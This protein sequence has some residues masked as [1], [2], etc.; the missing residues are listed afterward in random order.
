MSSRGESFSVK[1]LRQILTSLLPFCTSCVVYGLEPVGN[2]NFS[3]LLRSNSSGH[4]ELT[5]D[6][7]LPSPWTPISV[8][9]GTLDG[10]GHIISGLNVTTH[11]KHKPAG[12]FAIV[13]DGW[14]RG[15]VLKEP[16]VASYDEYSS[17]GAIA[18][19]VT[20]S[21]ITDSSN[22]RGQVT[23]FWVNPDKSQ[24]LFGGSPAGGIV[25]S[26]GGASRIENVVHTGSVT[27][28]GT[29][30][31]AGGVVGYVSNG[32]TV[33]STLNTGQVRTH[34]NRAS[35]G[36]VSGAL[37]FNSTISNTLNTGPVNTIGS[38]A[39]AG[40]AAGYVTTSCAVS[41]SL[42]TGRV[43]TNGAYADAGGMMG[44]LMGRNIVNNSLNTGRVSTNGTRAYVGGVVG[45][46]GAGYFISHSLNTGSVSGNGRDVCAAGTVGIQYQSTASFSLNTGTVSSNG[47]G[48]C[49]GGVVGWQKD[50]TASDSLNSG[51]VIERG[52]TLNAAQ[53]RDGATEITTGLHGLNDTFWQAGNN[54]S[55]PMLK[56]INAAYRDLQR[57]NGTRHGNNDFPVV[58]HQFVD[59]GGPANDSLFDQVVWNVRDGY[60]PFLKGINGVQAKKAGIDCGPGGFACPDCQAMP[61]SP[62]TL[63]YLLYDGQ[64]YHGIV[65]GDNGLAYWIAYE[66]GGPVLLEPCGVYDFA[67]LS[68]SGIV[69]DAAVYHDNRAYVAYHL[70]GQTEPV[71]SILATFTLGEGQPQP[72]SKSE[73]DYQ[74]TGLCTDDD[75][76]VLVKTGQNICQLDSVMSGDCPV[77]DVVET[78]EVIETVAGNNGDLYLLT[79][80]KDDGYRIRTVPEVGYQTDFMVTIPSG[81]SERTITSLKVSGQYLHLLLTDRHSLVWRQYSLAALRM[82]FEEAW[83]NE[84]AA[85]LPQDITPEAI[86]LIPGREAGTEDQ[87]FILGYRAGMQPQYAQLKACD[88]T[89]LPGSSPGTE[90]KKSKTGISDWPWWGQMLF[91][92]GVS[93]VAV[94]ALALIA[95]NVY[96]HCRPGAKGETGSPSKL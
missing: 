27:T 50:S 54:N 96:M 35:A 23:T 1:S 89:P 57:I 26:A 52:V 82:M 44:R 33:N 46:Q 88:F 47:T 30:S 34:G 60:L 11:G 70:P 8:F 67:D 22:I 83:E 2:A 48:A 21:N 69:A 56:G 36:G 9:A 81:S 31:Y 95:R 42:N 86:T 93:A 66:N 94:T 79:Y 84:V 45:Q 29:S 77:S 25:G 61:E 13:L 16:Y 75:G 71:N 87:V 65:K 91:G 10:R 51:Q 62:G 58:L 12:L 32:S 74:I 7:N 63:E 38:H 49:V 24:R 4:F 39:H 19:R 92:G 43:S 64:R 41:N 15:L 90:A 6:I 78:S 3:S 17:A 76:D 85:P 73:L 40:G 37:C 53:W 28:H 18:G 55:Y 5:E 14:I 59:P 68:S 72:A 20:R 80:G